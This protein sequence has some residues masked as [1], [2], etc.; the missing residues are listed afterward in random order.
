MLQL[1]SRSSMVYYEL[2][3]SVNK[4]ITFADKKINVISGWMEISL[5]LL[6]MLLDEE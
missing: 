6:N 5:F 1:L 2:G 4:I 3:D